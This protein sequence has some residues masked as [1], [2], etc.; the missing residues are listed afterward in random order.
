MPARMRFSVWTGSLRPTDR[1]GRTTALPSGP[2]P[3]P[4]PRDR[5][6]GA[7]SGIA[8]SPQAARMRQPNYALSDARSRQRGRRWTHSASFDIISVA[9]SP[10]YSISSWLA[11]VA[12]N[13]VTNADDAF[14]QAGGLLSADPTAGMGEA[15]PPRTVHMPL[16]RCRHSPAAR[17]L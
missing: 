12:H 3:P 2:E 14:H 15:S 6:H 1:S 4:R 11:R 10:V 16:T 7:R 13:G 8:Q 9:F 17:S 5:R